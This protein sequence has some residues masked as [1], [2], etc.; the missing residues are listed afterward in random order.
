MDI[1]RKHSWPGRSISKESTEEEEEWHIWEPKWRFHSRLQGQSTSED[2]LENQRGV[3]SWK[4]LDTYLEISSSFWWLL[5]DLIKE[6]TQC[7]ILCKNHPSCSIRNEGDKNGCR[8]KLITMIVH[9]KE[10][11]KCGSAYWG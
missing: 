9:M 11:G 4:P 3:R 8:E 1:S 7:D 2:R 6:V 5:E 10:N